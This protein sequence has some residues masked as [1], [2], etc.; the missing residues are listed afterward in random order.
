M[1]NKKGVILLYAQKAYGKAKK[2]GKLQVKAQQL[3]QETEQEN[4]RLAMF[5]SLFVCLALIAII[6][7]SAV[8]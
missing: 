5:I 4:K 8:K 1:N 3:W 7:L 2:A 6:F